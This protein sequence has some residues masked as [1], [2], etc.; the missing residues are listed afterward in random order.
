MAEQNENEPSK[1][2]LHE[3][4]SELRNDAAQKRGKYEFITKADIPCSKNQEELN[5]WTK[6]AK[7]VGAEAKA[8][9]DKQIRFQQ[10]N[11]TGIAQE[12]KAMREGKPLDEDERKANESAVRG[13]EDLENG[14]KTQEGYEAGNRRFQARI[15]RDEQTI[16]QQ[17][18][19]AK[20]DRSVGDESSARFAEKMQDAAYIDRDRAF[21][22]EYAFRKNYWVSSNDK[23]SADASAS[24][25][26]TK[27]AGEENYWDKG[28]SAGDTK[29]ESGA[30]AQQ[31]VEASNQSDATEQKSA[32]MD[33][34][35]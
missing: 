19:L 16:S 35:L 13:F 3:H 9:E 33:K 23:D 28:M 8:A 21:E 15:D 18:Y 27:T 14:R 5:H 10:D 29:G 12:S 26:E 22:E 34:R 24:A 6:E 4:L 2:P 30:S 32:E 20:L 1:Y 17:R 31:T 11:K 25:E 7:Q